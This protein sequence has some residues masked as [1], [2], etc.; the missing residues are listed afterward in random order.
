MSNLYIYCL[1]CIQLKR[2]PL[3]VDLRMHI[4]VEINLEIF[5]NHMKI[6][7]FEC[8]SLQEDFYTKYMHKSQKPIKSLTMKG[9]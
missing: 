2:Q 9:R 3:S 7:K 5:E 1:F 6:F 8:L 4:V